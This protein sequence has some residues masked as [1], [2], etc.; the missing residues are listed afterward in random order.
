MNQDNW[1]VPHTFHT[2]DTFIDY[3]HGQVEEKERWV[4]SQYEY[5]RE[6][7]W[8]W[9]AAGLRDA[10][11][12]EGL[13]LKKAVV[14]ASQHVA[15]ESMA[16]QPWVADLLRCRSFPTRDWN[17]LSQ[18]ERHQIMQ[19]FQT[20]KIRPLLTPDLWTARRL[21]REF[22]DHSSPSQT[23]ASAAR[24]LLLKSGAVYY[25]VISV[26]FSESQTNI[27]KR[28]VA[29]LRCLDIVKM[30]Q[31]HQQRVDGPIGKR[32]RALEPS[33][34]VPLI[35]G[36]YSWCLFEID[37]SA[38]KGDLKKDFSNW[39]ARHE[40]RERFQRYQKNRRGKTG[41]SLDR[42]KD[43]AAWRLYRENDND[44][45]QAN[46]IAN[47]RRK[48]KLITATRDEPLPFHNARAVDGQTVSEADLFAC[49]EDYRHAKG[50]ALEYLAEC[51]PREF[52]R[53]P[54]ASDWDPLS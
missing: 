51:F 19:F 48:T 31:T 46:F 49:D 52:G 10:N 2:S 3:L 11:L 42:L 32:V 24:A 26:D 4:A 14:S 22:S 37:F 43:L 5:A 39:L 15:M 1:K 27:I 30:R 36:P 23:P 25:A 21:F 17:G 50:R 47:K 8:S 29:W 44:C 13:S 35:P 20:Q 12:S 53:P 33:A 6:S 41:D 7:R 40:N 34:Q 18:A 54:L 16:F 45:G 28:F 38:S 9:E